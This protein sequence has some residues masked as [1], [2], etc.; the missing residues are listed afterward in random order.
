MATRLPIPV[1]GGLEGELD[2]G[3]RARPQLDLDVGRAAR[4]RARSAND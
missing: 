4:S 3:R 2:L 1:R